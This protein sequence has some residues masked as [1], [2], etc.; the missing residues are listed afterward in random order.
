MD[1]PPVKIN[2][3][4]EVQVG[5]EYEHYN[6]DKSGTTNWIQLKIYTRKNTATDHKELLCG[7]CQK[8]VDC[9]PM[10]GCKHCY[11]DSCQK[12][13]KKKLDIGCVLCF[14]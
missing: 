6:P 12:K 4:K 9:K 11:H 1:E 14:M 13:L 10:E 3:Q 2:E 5:D 7:I 8:A